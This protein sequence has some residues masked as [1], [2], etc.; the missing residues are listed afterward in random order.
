MEDIPFDFIVNWDQTGVLGSWTMEK[1]GSKR[2]EI[3]GVDDKRKITTVFAGSLAG[4]FLPPQLIYKGTTQRCLPTIQFPPDWHVTHCENH[5][6][7]ESMM[8]AY[9]ERILLPYLREKRKQLKLRANYT[10]L[11]IFGKSTGQGTES[12]LRITTST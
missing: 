1:E 12:S 5:W 9:I 7:N 4:D 10:A 3:A 6:S 8:K 11:V 2:V